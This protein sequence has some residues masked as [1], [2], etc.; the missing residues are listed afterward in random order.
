MIAIGVILMFFFYAIT[1]G[2]TIACKLYLVTEQPAYN[3]LPN[4]QVTAAD[5]ALCAMCIYNYGKTE[6]FGSLH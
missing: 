2:I 4:E 1:E 5:T 3:I 6:A